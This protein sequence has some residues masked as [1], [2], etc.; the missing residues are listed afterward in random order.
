MGPGQ[1]EEAS[2]LLSVHVHKTKRRG[3]KRDGLS[4]PHLVMRDKRVDCWNS[5]SN[6]CQRMD[7]VMEDVAAP[8]ITWAEANYWREKACHANDMRTKSNT[9]KKKIKKNGF[10]ILGTPGCPWLMW[11]SSS[12]GGWL[13]PLDSW[14]LIVHS[15]I[16]SSEEAAVR[17]R[18]SLRWWR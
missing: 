15:C 3:E 4:I 1:N 12:S 14:L 10:F 2:F 7:D 8:T 18:T 6:N 11:W 13:L 9:T 17:S 16:H 5:S